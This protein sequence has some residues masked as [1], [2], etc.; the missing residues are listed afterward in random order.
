[1]HFRI[2]KVMIVGER[3]VIGYFRF[4]YFIIIK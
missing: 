1:M 4:K 3:Q 2:E